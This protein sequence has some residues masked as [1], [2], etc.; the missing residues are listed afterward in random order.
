MSQIRPP[1]SSLT[2]NEIFAVDATSAQIAVRRPHQREGMVQ[3]RVED[4]V[5]PIEIRN[6]V[7]ISTIHGLT[8]EA[9]FEIAVLGPQGDVVERLRGTCAPALPNPVKV[10]TISDVHLGAEGF[11]PAR[12]IRDEA[13]VPYALRCGRS[14]IEEALAWG[15][16]ALIIK[17]DLTDT[18]ARA[19]WQLAD[20]LLS[21]IAVPILI[22]SGNHDVWGTREVMP[23]EGTASIGQSFDDVQVLDVGPLRIVLV[24]TSLPG[25]GWGDLGRHEHQIVAAVAEEQPTLLCLHHHVQRLPAPWFWPPGISP[26]NAAPVLQAVWDKNPFVLVTSGHTHRNRR[27][28]LLNGKVTFTEVSATSDYPGVWAGYEVTGEVIRQTVRRIA[29]PEATL[30]TEATRAALGSVWPRWSQ[31]R[32]YD[33]C[34]DVSASGCR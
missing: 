29:A 14:A 10:A 28:Q 30:W 5:I 7:G 27:H 20:T 21:G 9:P 11:G 17:G 22:T 1:F 8:P 12:K 3:V 33:R 34:V 31:G 25:R 26:K 4:R 2:D 19:E 13:T 24:D 6:G 18:G 23:A 32:L 15:A 16:E